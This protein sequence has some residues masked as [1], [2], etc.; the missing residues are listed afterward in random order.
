MTDTKLFRTIAIN[1]K[2]GEW[3]TFWHIIPT[4]HHQA[5]LNWLKKQS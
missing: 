5:A 2:T 1:R 3:R 4:K